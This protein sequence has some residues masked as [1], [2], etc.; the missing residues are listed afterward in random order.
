MGARS[1]ANA[2]PI[3]SVALER[4]AARFVEHQGHALL[5]RPAVERHR[6]HELAL[7]QAAVGM[8]VDRMEDAR[9]ARHPVDL[10]RIGRE[11]GA[12]VTVRMEGGVDLQPAAAWT[13]VDHGVLR[14][15]GVR[16]AALAVEEEP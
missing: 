12:Y 7:L 2:R 11:E 5:E 3:P 4:R 13:P 16:Q 1:Y 15:P 9:G 10:E 14:E 6:A 8:Q